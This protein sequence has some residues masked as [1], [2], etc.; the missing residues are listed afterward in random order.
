MQFALGALGSRH[1]RNPG[2]R[3]RAGGARFVTFLVTEAVGS[4]LWP[5]GAPSGMQLHATDIESDHW[6]ATCWAALR[7]SARIDSAMATVSWSPAR[8][9]TRFSSS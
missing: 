6:S 8:S 3:G 4:V 2:W 7:S 5:T 1:G 9:A